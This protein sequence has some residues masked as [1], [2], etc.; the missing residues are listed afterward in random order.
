[1]N[2]FIVDEIRLRN[3]IFCFPKD[4]CAKICVEES[5]TFLQDSN[6]DNT[7]NNNTI[8][9]LDIIE[10]NYKLRLSKKF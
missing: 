4:R 8:A 1:M 2:Q 5:K 6:N 9:T 10:V 3:K 7:S